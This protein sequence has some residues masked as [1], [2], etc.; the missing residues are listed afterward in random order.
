MS[1]QRSSQALYQ[2]GYSNEERKDHKL[3]WPRANTGFVFSQ[4]GGFHVLKEECDV[5]QFWETVDVLTRPLALG[6]RALLN[7]DMGAS[8]ARTICVVLQGWLGLLTAC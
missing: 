1:G 7:T 6:A 5:K 3:K 2:V 8:N 4:E